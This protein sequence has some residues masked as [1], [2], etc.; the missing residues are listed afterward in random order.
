MRNRLSALGLA[1][2]MMFA[3]AAPIAA[4]QPSPLRACDV[5]QSLPKDIIAHLFSVSP[6]TA[7][8]LLA[9]LADAC[10]GG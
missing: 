5:V 3:F 7:E 8:R 6:A 1:L 2:V 9:L 10:Q 4:A